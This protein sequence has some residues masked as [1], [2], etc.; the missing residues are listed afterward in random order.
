M[1]LK[2]CELETHFS[3]LG[4][5]VMFYVKLF[6]FC[7]KGK[8]HF[9]VITPTV[10]W[11]PGWQAAGGVENSYIDPTKTMSASVMLLRTCTAEEIPRFLSVPCFPRL[12]WEL[13]W[14]SANRSCWQEGRDS[15]ASCQRHLPLTASNHECLASSST[16]G[17]TFEFC[18][19]AAG[20]SLAFL[21]AVS[22][23]FPK[24]SPN[25]LL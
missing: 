11:I 20:R 8:I 6:N 18:L 12:Y 21:E 1:F 16:R 5:A 2:N 7:I 3:G 22:V 9:L 14:D 24:R 23:A 19:A 17:F 15:R 10:Q 4:R 13:I 25:S